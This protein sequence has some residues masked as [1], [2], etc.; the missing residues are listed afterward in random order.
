MKPIILFGKGKIA[1]VILASIK[2]IGIQEVAAITIDKEYLNSKSWNGLDIVPFDEVNIFYPPEEFD[3]FVAIGYHQLNKIREEKYAEAKNKGYKLINI[4][5]PNILN[6]YQ[7]N[8]GDNCFIM[9]NSNIHPKVKIGNNVF[10][11]SGALVGH[12]SVISDN[13]WITSAANIAS[14]VLIGS[15]SFIGLNATI[16][17]S[18]SIGNDN[19]IGANTLITK[20]SEDGQVFLPNAS[21]AISLNSSQFLRLSKVF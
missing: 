11:W 18:I 1:D 9:P 21:K 20:S 10:I 8:L 16:T 4:V 13:V 7:L 3:M 5:E 2:Y 19:F 12:H 17:N 6:K 15:N 14:D